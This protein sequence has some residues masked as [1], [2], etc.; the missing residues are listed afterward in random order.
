MF[1]T[2]V[3]DVLVERSSVLQALK[4]AGTSEGSA[5]SELPEGMRQD[6]F[7]QW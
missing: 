7:F 4:E 5:I 3:D 6:D 2:P 1:C